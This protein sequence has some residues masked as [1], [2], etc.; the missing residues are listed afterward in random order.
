MNPDLSTVA[1]SAVNFLPELVLAVAFLAATAV[2]ALRGGASG[3]VAG[4]LALL[5]SLAAG[6]LIVVV[7]I[8]LLSDGAALHGRSVGSFNAEWLFKGSEQPY[9]FGMVMVDGVGV[10][11][12][13]LLAFASCVC[14]IVAMWSAELRADAGR[15][16]GMVFPLVLALLLG[17]FVMCGANDLILMYAGLECTA[18][19]AYGLVAAARRTARASEAAMKHVVLGGVASAVLLFGITLLYGLLGT[20]NFAELGLLLGLPNSD[21]A[22]GNPL[23]IATIMIL[24][25]LCVKIAAAPFHFW[26]P[27]VAEAVPAPIGALIS[28]VSKCA[29]AVLAV[30]FLCVVF[31]GY[32][33]GFDLAPVLGGLAALTMTLGNLAAMQ[34]T[35]V[36][37]ML[38]YA[39]VAQGGVML[40]A[41]AAATPAAIASLLIALVGYV[42]TT[43][44]AFIALERMAVH[45]GSDE[46]ED[47]RGLGRRMPLVGA[48]FSIAMLSFAALP[49]TSGFIGRLFVLTALFD[50]GRGYLWLAILCAANAL[51]ALYCALR[52]LKALYVDRGSERR[53]RLH[54]GA[55]RLLLIG[56]LCAAVLVV[57][58]PGALGTVVGAADDAVRGLMPYL[59]DGAAG[60]LVGH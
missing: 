8:P 6:V 60:T 5:G 19:A 52:V 1:V 53:D 9:G 13:L 23:V 28:V 43:L 18:L 42:G 55:G 4:W 32:M 37:R 54:V 7:Q 31:P 25:G 12:K 58:M 2:P 56:L 47:L 11:A 3:R 14:T 36:K 26:A 22:L 38:G 29:G 27:D 48:A 51:P 40:A 49:P 50:A 46:I 17:A 15:R 41:I 24:A 59:R 16:V 45:A 21:N 35:N 57:A 30:R 10:F 44:L 20:T 34:Q 33:Q 39:T